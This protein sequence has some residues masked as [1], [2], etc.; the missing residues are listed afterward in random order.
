MKFTGALN[1]EIKARIEA[2]DSLLHD[3]KRLD[4]LKR[5][6][7]MGTPR[8]LAFDRLAELAARVL[9]VPLTIVSFIGDKT[10]FFKASSGMPEPL[11]TLRE[12]PLDGSICRYTLRGEPI[13]VADASVDPLLMYHPATKPWGIVAFIALPMITHDGHVLGSF[14]AVDHQKREWSEDDIYVLRE[15]T[16][17]VMTE[18]NLRE[19][20]EELKRQQELRDRFVSVLTHDLRTPMTVVKMSSQLILKKIE[21][22]Q[23]VTELANRIVQNIDRAD[24]MIQEL[25]ENKEKPPFPGLTTQVKDSCISEAL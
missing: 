24:K 11:N 3:P 23:S 10:Q 15:L 18:I 21:N 14:C 9:R 13:I 19:Q 20:V 22:T 6:G 7:L 4:A 8:E 1:P 5:T 12:I 16:A 17:S 2:C 25:L